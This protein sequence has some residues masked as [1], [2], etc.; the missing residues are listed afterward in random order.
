MTRAR[1]YVFAHTE[2]GGAAEKE[3]WLAEL[4]NGSSLEISKAPTGGAADD[5]EDAKHSG[6]LQK[7]VSNEDREGST[8]PLFSRNQPFSIFAHSL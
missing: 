3:A 5:S 4:A 2:G 6:W 1:T 7:M 8:F